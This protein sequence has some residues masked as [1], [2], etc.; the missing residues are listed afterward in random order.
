MS[1]Y[2]RPPLQTNPAE[3]VAGMV[4]GMQA[5]V[6]GWQPIQGATDT[7]IIEVQGFQNAIIAGQASGTFDNIFAVAGNSLFG[8]EPDIATYAVADST[9]TLT[10]EATALGG[11]IE[12]GSEVKVQV[13]ATEAIGFMVAEDVIVAPGAGVSG[14]GEVPLVALVAG[15]EGSGLTG[16]ALKVTPLDFIASIEIEGISQGGQDAEEWETYLDRMTRR[17]RRLTFGIVRAEDA[18]DAARDVDGVARVLVIDNFVPGVNEMQDVSVDATSG[19]FTLTYSG[20]TTAAIAFNATA[21]T[22]QDRLE[23]LSNIQV[24][25][26]I[27]TLGPLATAAVRVE[28]ANL[29]GQQDVAAMTH[30]DSLSGGGAAATVT[31]VRAGSAEVTNTAKSFTVIPIASDGLPVATQVKTNVIA[32]LEL[33]R[34]RGFRF[35]VMDPVYTTVD[36]TFDF[37]TYP[38]FDP[39]VV[40]AAAEA[41]GTAALSPQYHGLAP[42]GDVALWIDDPWVR[43]SEVYAALNAVEGLHNALNVELNGFVDTDIA[44]PG[45]GGLPLPGVVTATAL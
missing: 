37:S 2:V 41:A 40:G 38:G 20:Q 4:A 36:L 34:E 26:V 12:A 25:D 3:V 11:T 8:I 44:L 16:T 7:A 28:F 9:W 6:P 33:G 27:C 18:E 14:V 5:R 42:Y 13:T 43:Y 29:L 22:V 32:A 31:T 19:S 1:D 21:T 15:A 23:A 39:I 30:T 10:A 24:G 17:L 35:A 45:P